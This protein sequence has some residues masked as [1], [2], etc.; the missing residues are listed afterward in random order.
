MTHPP[1]R[2]TGK[3]RGAQIL[4]AGITAAVLLGTALATSPAAAYAADPVLNSASGVQI[5]DI[6]GGVLENNT[7]LSQWSAGDDVT[8]HS[9]G[10][11]S[12]FKLNTTVSTDITTTAGISGSTATIA[13][14]EY[15]LRARPPVLFTGLRS[16]CAPDGTSTVSFDSLSVDGADLT[17]QANDTASTPAGFNYDLPDSMYGPTRI[18]VGER[19]TGADGS[20]KVTGLRVEAE[21]GA[22]EIWRVRL[23]EVT[24][25][26]YPIEVPAPVPA[27]LPTPVPAPAPDPAPAPTSDPAPAP[28]PAPVTA[29][30]LVSG[31]TVTAQDGTVLI[32]GEPR[33]TEAGTQTAESITA[34]SFPTTAANVT[35]TAGDD[36]TASASVGRFSQI[37]DT[38]SVGE[39]R[40]NA[41]RVY[42]LNLQVD[43]DGA[44][45][46][47]FKDVG[48]A[49]FVNGVWINTATDL[50]TGLDADGNERVLVHFNERTTNA[51]GSTT[52]TALRY[53]DLTGVN[54]DVSLGRVHLPAAQTEP[55]DPVQ[56]VT[57]VSGVRV[58]AADGTVLIDGVPQVTDAGT[59]ETA[60]TIKAEDFPT[61]AAD[62]TVTAG[63]DG[64]ASASIGRFSQIPDTSSVGEF[65]WNAL[66]VY[67][68]NLEVDADGASAVTFKDVGS[69]VFVNGVWINTATDL[70][71]GLDADGN[72]RVLVHFNERTTNADGSTT[73]TALRYEDLTGVNPDVSLGQVVLSPATTPTEPT[74]PTEPVEP[75]VPPAPELARWYSYGV[76]ATGPSPVSA[77]P[78]VE[79][80][81]GAASMRARDAGDHNH[82]HDDEDVVEDAADAASD[83]ASGQISATGITVKAARASASSEAATVSL[84]PHTR[85]AVSLDDLRVEVTETSTVVTSAGGTVAGTAIPAGEIAPNTVFSVAGTGMRIML[86]EQIAVDDDLTVIGVHVSDP[87]GLAA[88]VRVAAVTTIAPA[89][90]E[91]VEP[92]EP[93]TGPGEPGTEP[94]EPGTEPAEPVEPGTPVAPGTPG[95]PGMEPG[96]PVQPGTP[97]AEPGTPSDPGAPST[98][99][100]PGATPAEPGEPGATPAEPG[101]PGANP[102]EPGATPDEPGVEP[103]D[104]GADVPVPGVTP[105]DPGVVSP[106]PGAAPADPGG[107]GSGSGDSDLRPGAPSADDGTSP[108][109]GGTEG[110][111][112]AATG[113]LAHTGTDALSAGLL[114]LLLCAAGAVLV[115]AR[116]RS[117][118]KH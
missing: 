106:A 58:I 76:L 3:P 6:D 80:A 67:G 62:V 33:I 38:S 107:I 78:L 37:P 13:S 47:T 40:W 7:P 10:T 44:S 41:L 15:T 111:T 70:Y 55:V 65:R 18:I 81:D 20:L 105:T 21:S 79:A 95:R 94:G 4:T 77:R 72:E 11:S 82:D 46:V 5:F 56:G 90:V 73:I 102:A 50:Y 68:L 52:I 31:V 17:A 63:D 97:G 74:E 42:G 96:Q 87:T 19:R 60:E 101:Q 39:F 75:V 64:T 61:T 91:P 113:G 29:A 32:D 104:P 22:S 59:T 53:E 92:G 99:G 118:V 51:D 36:G 84:Y 1:Q 16:T 114:A 2:R 88:D 115:I 34:E 45:A 103:T 117:A 28:D 57:S 116:R 89:V 14:G 112:A 24:C 27:P 93:G 98:P 109:A 35:V 85:S 48:S 69:A 30:P 23:A 9:D 108:A 83:S 26:S 49:V 66:R 8:A 43:A 86:N 12:K 25:A 110:S 71:T 100:E 54:P